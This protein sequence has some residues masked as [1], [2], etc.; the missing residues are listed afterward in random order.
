MN[1][2]TLKNVNHSS[3][4]VDGEQYLVENLETGNWQVLIWYE[5]TRYFLAKN[6]EDNVP[7]GKCTVYRFPVD[8]K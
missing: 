8:V 2:L 7:W 1:N 3:L 5:R 4:L 6:A